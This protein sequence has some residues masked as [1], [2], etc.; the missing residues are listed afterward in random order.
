LIAFDCQHIVTA[1]ALHDALGNI[2][3]G[4]HGVASDSGPVQCGNLIEESPRGGQF[5]FLLFRFALP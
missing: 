2:T 3:V 5:P 4:K 1:L